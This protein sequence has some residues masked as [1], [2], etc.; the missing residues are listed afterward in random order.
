LSTSS[1]PQNTNQKFFTAL[2]GLFGLV[3]PSIKADANL[4]DQ[5]QDPSPITATVGLIEDES[6]I[7][8]EG[9]GHQGII[10]GDYIKRGSRP[11]LVPVRGRWRL[12]H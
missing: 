12:A 11:W 3:A 6:V 9:S 8:K 7:E 2:V 4:F 1:S 10:G 5:D